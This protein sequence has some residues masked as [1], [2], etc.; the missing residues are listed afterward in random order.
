MLWDHK[1]LQDHKEPLDPPVKLDTL[2]LKVLQ[3]HKVFRVHKD[4]QVL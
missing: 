3:D 4:Q 2:V 1:V